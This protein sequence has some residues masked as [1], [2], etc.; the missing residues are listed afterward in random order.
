MGL[1]F[2]QEPAGAVV[3]RV[4]AANLRFGGLPVEE[5]HRLGELNGRWRLSLIRQ[6]ATGGRLLEVGC[7]R[8]DFLRVAREC[9]DV[10]GVEPNP[11]L[12]REG[13]QFAT[14]YEGLVEHAP[15]S[16]F[17]VAVAFHV[18]EHV[19]SPSQ[20]VSGIAGR[21]KPGGLLVVETPNIGSVPY[22][23]FRSR[24]RQFIPEHYYF[25]DRETISRLLSKRGFVV[26]KVTSVGKYASPILIFDRLSRY[27]RI[28]R[29]GGG[30]ARAMRLERAA[31]RVNP[32]DIMMIFATKS[33]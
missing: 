4:R 16:E 15:W 11:E 18:I 32:L 2:G 14:V 29:A 1:A 19:D 30:L 25:F 3:H 6:F 17:D 9:F 12:A 28:G 27:F 33:E 10:Y 7:A 23:L 22:R 26:R 13:Q 5:E 8:G 24:W 21:L 20:F 31:F